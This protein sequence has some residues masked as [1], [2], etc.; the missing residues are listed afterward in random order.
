MYYFIVDVLTKNNRVTKSR[1]GRWTEHLAW[2]GKRLV[3]KSQRHMYSWE[4]DIKMDL[5]E[6][7]YKDVE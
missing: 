6:V 2:I 1:T 4:N 3:S 7:L 5:T